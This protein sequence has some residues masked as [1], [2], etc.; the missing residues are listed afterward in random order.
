MAVV[1]T[2]SAKYYPTVNTWPGVTTDTPNKTYTLTQ[3]ITFQWNTSGPPSNYIGW[4]TLA[5]G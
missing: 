3:D 5:A 2:D 4:A 1:I